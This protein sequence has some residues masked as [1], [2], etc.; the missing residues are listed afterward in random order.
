[1]SSSSGLLEL[2]T[3]FPTEYGKLLLLEPAD[4]DRVALLESIRSGSYEKPFIADDGDARTLYFSLIYVQSCMRLKAPDALELAYTRKMMAFL[5]F[6]TNPRSLL[7]LGLGGGSLA[8]FCHRHLPQ[9]KIRAVE[10]SPQV[11]AFREQFCV[12][13]DDERFQVIEADA[14]EYLAATRGTPGGAKALRERHD[15]IMID[16]FDRHGLAS[17]ISTPAFY[18]DVRAALLPRGV[19]VCNLAGLREE[20]VAHLEL[21]MSVFGDNLLVLPVEDD[22]NEIVFAFCD[23]AFEPRWRWI[24][25]QALAMRSRYGLDFPKFAAKLERA[26]K[27]GYLQRSLG[28][29]F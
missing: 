9:A 27:L 1:M 16:A 18:A 28:G 13:P 7:L 25:S 14:A 11:I 23:T 20:R 12:P 29:G 15:I 4:A 22:G 26:S 5:L 6:H 24:N 10:I 2:P 17:S 8:K 19:L 21:M 3:P